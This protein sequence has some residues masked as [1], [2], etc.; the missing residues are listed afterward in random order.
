ML[1]YHGQEKWN[2]KTDLRDMIPGFGELPN[3]FKKKGTSFKYDF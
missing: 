1:I 2:L 3:Y